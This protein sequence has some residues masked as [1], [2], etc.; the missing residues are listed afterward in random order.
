M[1]W[2]MRSVSICAIMKS[3]MDTV[4]SKMDSCKGWEHFVRYIAQYLCRKI[5]RI[6]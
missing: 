4:K 3:I 2:V 6:R 5:E 1:V